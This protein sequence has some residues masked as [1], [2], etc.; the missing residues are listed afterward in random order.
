[1]S[2]TGIGGGAAGLENVVD[3]LLQDVKTLPPPTVD[4]LHPYGTVA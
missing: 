1:M 3:G 2:T 4:A